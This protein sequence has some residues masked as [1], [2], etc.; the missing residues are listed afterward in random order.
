MTIDSN[1]SP[2]DPFRAFPTLASKALC[3]YLLRSVCGARPVGRGQG[4]GTR[5]RRARNRAPT[6]LRPFVSDSDR[7][8]VTTPR[9]PRSHPLVRVLLP[10]ARNSRSRLA[11][12]TRIHLSVLRVPGSTLDARYGLE[13]TSRAQRVYTAKWAARCRAGWGAR[14]A[15]CSLGA[16]GRRHPERGALGPDQHGKT[17]KAVESMLE[18]HSGSSACRC[19]S[20]ARNLRSCQ[21]SA[22]EDRVALVTGE[23][24]RVPRRSDYWILHDRGHAAHP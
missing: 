17:H 5:P 13:S 20:S 21:R 1:F 18:H 23:E 6:G 14:A 4:D 16:A 11:S 7:A 22:G 3:L 15:P 8:H 24:K 2:A 19:G 10:L 9:V 12:A